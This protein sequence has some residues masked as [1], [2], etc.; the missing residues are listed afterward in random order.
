MR[1]LRC[2]SKGLAESTKSEKERISNL[3]DTV[4]K[5]N[6]QRDER[7]IDSVVPNDIDRRECFRDGLLGKH[8]GKRQITVL[9][10]LTL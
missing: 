9:K 2:H 5:K 4:P 6:P 10:K 7:C 3:K 1:G 8:V